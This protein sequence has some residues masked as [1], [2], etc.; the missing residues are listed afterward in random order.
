MADNCTSVHIWQCI[1]KGDLT[2]IFDHQWQIT[3]LVFTYEL[4]P[5]MDEDVQNQLECTM[6]HSQ[7]TDSS[8]EEFHF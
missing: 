7:N 6:D 4:D 1:P 2:V 5:Y 8:P 3:V